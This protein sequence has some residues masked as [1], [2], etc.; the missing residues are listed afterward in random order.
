MDTL[1]SRTLKRFE[2]AVKSLERALQLGDLPDNAD[3]DTLLLRFQLAAELMPKTIQRILAERGAVPALPKDIVRTAR[4][5]DMVGERIAVALLSIIDDRN[6]MVH[7]YSEEYALALTSRVKNEYV[8]IL[9]ELLKDLT[10]TS[11]T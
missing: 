8:S 4:A 2:K 11:I 10:H 9:Q 3:R 5:A 6:R 1:A 7:D